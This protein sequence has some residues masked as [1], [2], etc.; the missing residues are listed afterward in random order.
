MSPHGY[1]SVDDVIIDLADG[2]ATKPV[3][4]S[5]GRET[6]EIGRKRF[7]G[8]RLAGVVREEEDEEIGDDLL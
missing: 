8:C 4:A 3:V 7:P 2:I 1:A 5:D 6:F